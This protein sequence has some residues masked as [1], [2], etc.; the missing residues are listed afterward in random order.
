MKCFYASVECADRGLNPFETALV[1]ADVS[2]GKNAICLAVSPKLKSLGIKNRCR[3]NDIPLNIDYIAVKPRMKRYIEY[4][5]DIYDIYLDYISPD[6]IHVYSIDEMFLDV[7]S[8]LN[9]YRIKPKDFAIKL[10]KEIENRLKIPSTCGIGT[11]LYLSKIAL[12]ITAKKNKDHLGFLNEELFK[13]T[14][15]NH[16]PLT[17]FW[18]IS[19]G[20]VNRLKKYAIYDMQN[21]LDT[22]EH[23]LYKEFGVNAE[24]LIDH[25][26]GRESCTMADLKN[27]KTKSKS[28]SNSQ[29]LFEN[30]DAEK[31]F[32]VL[33]E[34]TLTTTQELL[35]RK[36]ITSTVSVSIGYSNDFYSS[37]GGSLK[38]PFATQS[39]NTIIEHVRTLFYKHVDLRKPIRRLGISFSS[40]TDE[41]AEGYDFFTNLNDLEREKKLEKSVLNIKEKYGKNAI[42]RGFD[43]LD[44]ATQ[45]ERNTMI[46]GH[47]GE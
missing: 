9:T 43:F 16:T 38:L 18:G 15:L 21:I 12:D 46:G 7:T 22:P 36:L 13:L 39:Y 34:M 30:Y 47:N 27:Y 33:Q 8:Y 23:L 32:L 10:M 45:K 24:L 3:I 1:V 6:D 31:A 11:N 14:L 28:I 19:K 41:C 40:L 5:A 29:I 4:S 26:N 44:G 25:A 17:D 20:T 42:L 35:K 2:R 37:S